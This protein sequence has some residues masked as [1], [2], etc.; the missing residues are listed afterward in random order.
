MPDNKSESSDRRFKY[1][2]NRS[3]LSGQSALPVVEH[4]MITRFSPKKPFPVGQDDFLY[5]LAS[6]ISDG[7]LCD[8]K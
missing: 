8:D 5:R 2:Q 4:T 6:M 1:R 3:Q 7:T